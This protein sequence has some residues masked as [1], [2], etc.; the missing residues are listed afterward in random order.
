MSPIFS[1]K[2]IQVSSHLKFFFSYEYCSV[3]VFCQCL[4]GGEKYPNFHS[5]KALCLQ[6]SVFSE[7]MGNETG[8][9][10]TRSPSASKAICWS[11]PKAYWY[12]CNYSSARSFYTFFY[13][14]FLS[15]L[16]SQSYRL[17]EFSGFAKG[18]VEGFATKRRI[19][20]GKYDWLKLC[21]E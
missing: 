14:P 10:P 18:F 21:L 12:F 17:S 7:C 4:F 19:L 1:V 9:S 15:I 5:L 11:S 16:K 2:T 20:K 6:Q 8:S 13:F 3:K